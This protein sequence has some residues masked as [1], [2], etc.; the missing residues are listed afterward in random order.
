MAKPTTSSPSG[1][2]DCHLRKLGWRGAHPIFVDV[3][4]VE[5][6]GDD[7]QLFGNEKK[8]PISEGFCFYSGGTSFSSVFIRSGKSFLTVSQT[9]A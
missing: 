1:A 7:S 2:V 5:G 3:I 6:L 8:L 9:A 4:A